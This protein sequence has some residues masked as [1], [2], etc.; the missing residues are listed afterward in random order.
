MATSKQFDW[1]K[2]IKKMEQKINKEKRQIHKTKY[3]KVMFAI[4]VIGDWYREA[5]LWCE[6]DTENNPTYGEALNVNLKYLTNKDCGMPLWKT[7]FK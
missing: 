5:V 6:D 1:N 4:K 7:S 3:K 2:H